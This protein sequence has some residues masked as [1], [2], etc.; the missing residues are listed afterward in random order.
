MN[1]LH[2]HVMH[3]LTGRGFSRS[4]RRSCFIVCL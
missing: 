4:Q 1:D 3:Y 2:L